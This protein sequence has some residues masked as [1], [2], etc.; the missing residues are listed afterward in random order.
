[1]HTTV[2]SDLMNLD[3]VPQTMNYLD[4]LPPCVLE[5]IADILW[6]DASPL[7]S[8]MHTRTRYRRYWIEANHL[9]AMACSDVL[10]IGTCL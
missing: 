9:Y 10:L 3:P 5:M 8:L 2:E 1:M 6:L 7:Q 4:L